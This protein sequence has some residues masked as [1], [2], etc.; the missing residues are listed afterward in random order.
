M[1]PNIEFNIGIAFGACAVAAFGGEQPW[2]AALGIILGGVIWM[3]LMWRN[4]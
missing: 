3:A 1:N 2:E 4:R